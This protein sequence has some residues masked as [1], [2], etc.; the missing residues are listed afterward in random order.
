MGD[1]YLCWQ[2][3]LPE[4]EAAFVWCFCSG[5]DCLPTAVT[6]K[7]LPILHHRSSLYAYIVRCHWSPSLSVFV[8]E[9]S[10]DCLAEV[11]GSGLWH[12]GQSKILG[13]QNSWPGGT[14]H[15][16]KNPKVGRKR[17]RELA[18]EDAETFQYAHLG[19]NMDDSTDH[20]SVELGS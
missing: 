8:I 14:E 11:D 19:V 9:D 7:Y 10:C 20:E 3:A 2:C 1:R 5:I 17:A 16:G 15:L 18:T 13:R 12:R 4:S 6:K